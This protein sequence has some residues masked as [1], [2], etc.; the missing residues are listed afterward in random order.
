MEVYETLLALSKGV[1][2][3]GKPQTKTLFNVTVEDCGDH[4]QVYKHDKNC[5]SKL[6][7]IRRT[8]DQFYEAEDNVYGKQKWQNFTRALAYLISPRGMT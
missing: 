1:V 4:V 3:S 5:S 6:G 8:E 7:N 2:D